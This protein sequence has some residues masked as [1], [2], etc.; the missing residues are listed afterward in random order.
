VPSL[1]NS[2]IAAIGLAGLTLA[3]PDAAF[4]NSS[5]MEYFSR[6]ASRGDLPSLLNAEDRAFYREL[7]AAIDRSDW[8]RVQAMF[9]TPFH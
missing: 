9:A 3:A 5:A 1:N 8:A 4:A 7:F 6:Q 2:L